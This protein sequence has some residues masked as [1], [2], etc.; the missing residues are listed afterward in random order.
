MGWLELRGV[1]TSG[2][3]GSTEG[4]AEGDPG[5]ADAAPVCDAGPQGGREQAET[6]GGE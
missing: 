2:K 6:R 3:A 1:G 4:Q 5:H